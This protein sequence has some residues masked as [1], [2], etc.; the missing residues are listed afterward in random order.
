M[1]DCSNIP[2]AV[3]GLDWTG[4]ARAA[5]R[6][7]CQAGQLVAEHHTHKR[8]G[9]R[10]GGLRVSPKV[11]RA[12]APS[13]PPR[14][15][16]QPPWGRARARTSYGLAALNRSGIWAIV[17]CGRSACSSCAAVPGRPLLAAAG[18]FRLAGPK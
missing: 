5:R 8:A 10:M 13:W 11:G 12:N 7:R 6:K 2:V 18:G 1:A 15:R 14:G 17:G 9:K 3:E 16:L 4:Q